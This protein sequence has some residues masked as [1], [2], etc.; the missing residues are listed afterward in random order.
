MGESAAIPRRPNEADGLGGDPAGARRSPMSGPRRGIVDPASVPT[1]TIQLLKPDGTLVEDAEFEA[2]LKK[3]D[4]L[5]IYRFMTL[6]RRADAEATNLQR[7]GDLRVYTPLLGQEAAQ[8]GG[9]HALHEGEWNLP[10][11]REAALAVLRKIDP[12]GDLHK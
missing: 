11:Y 10:S 5:E 1:E 6:A 9:A 2:D 8:G 3:D 12:V 4:L 7:Q